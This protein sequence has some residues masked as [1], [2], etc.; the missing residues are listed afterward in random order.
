M[1]NR[2]TL[3][4]RERS[5]SFINLQQDLFPLLD[6][7]MKVNNAANDSINLE[8]LHQIKQNCIR[9]HSEST[10]IALVSN[11]VIVA[12]FAHHKD[13]AGIVRAFH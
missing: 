7:R 13:T 5:S 2:I 11:M 10:F 4:F 1:S 9:T 8:A 6:L 12:E 3:I